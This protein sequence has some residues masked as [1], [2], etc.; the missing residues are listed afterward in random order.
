[1]KKLL[2]IFLCFSSFSSFAQHDFSTVFLTVKADCNCFLQFAINKKP[3]GVL[4]PI[5][6]DT[7]K[8]GLTKEHSGFFIFCNSIYRM[9]NID[10]QTDG[11]YLIKAVMLCEPKKNKEI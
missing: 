9:Y 8:F 10:F 11:I 7:M 1:M 2:L 3:S 5:D 6:K 4:F